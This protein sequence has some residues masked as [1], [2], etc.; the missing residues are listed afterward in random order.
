MSKFEQLA[1]KKNEE[2]LLY[3]DRENFIKENYPQ[4]KS[5]YEIQELLNSGLDGMEV[6]EK[7]DESGDLEGLITYSLAEDHEKIPYLSVGI[8]LTREESQGEGVMKKLF[9][10]IKQVAEENNCEYITAVADTEDGDGFLLSN[11]FSEETDE[12][13]GREHLRLDL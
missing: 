3:E 4:D 10:Q 5:G 8:M 13:N 9:S 12:V 1:F 11:G 2:D 7:R 6:L